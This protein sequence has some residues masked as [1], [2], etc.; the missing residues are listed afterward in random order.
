MENLV[1]MFFKMTEAWVVPISR[2]KSKATENEVGYRQ[3]RLEI[4]SSPERTNA[5]WITVKG[6][7]DILLEG[8]LTSVQKWKQMQFRPA[9]SS[10][11]EWKGTNPRPPLH[12][13]PFK[14]KQMTTKRGEK[15]GCEQYKTCGGAA[16]RC[17]TPGRGVVRQRGEVWQGEGGLAAG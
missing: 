13:I 11:A 8:L 1:K 6:Q 15:G 3:Q 17:W 7:K 2:K 4:Q 9:P 16:G 12:L 5:L 10:K 14:T